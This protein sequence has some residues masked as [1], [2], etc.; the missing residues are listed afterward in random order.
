MKNRIEEIEKRLRWALHPLELVVIDDSDQHS[1]H[2]GAATGL[3]HFTVKIKARI[4]LGQKLA[5]RHRMIYTALGEMMKTDIHALKIDAKPA[6]SQDITHFI[7]TTLSALKAQDIT[8]LDVRSLTDVM[9]SMVICT[10]TSIRHSASVAEKL[11]R[12]MH[13]VGV[14]AFNRIEDQTDS[15]WILVDFLDTVVH[16]MLRETREFY[17]LEKLWSVTES[18]RANNT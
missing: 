4:F 6:T 12:A 1:G 16:I 5:E 13:S 3:G 7:T 2:P 9:D 14:K 18:K 11:I 8:V 15:G 10:G 17:S